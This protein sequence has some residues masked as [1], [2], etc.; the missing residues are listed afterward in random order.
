[1]QEAIHTLTQW[2]SANPGWVTGTVFL[3]ALV[4]SLAVAGLVVPG[5]AILFAVAVL[6]G[7]AGI[8][9]MELLAWGAAGA[10]IGD[11]ISF[12][13][14][15]RLRGRLHQVWPFSRYPQMI[16]RAER[17]FVRHG[18]KSVVIGRFVGPV[19]PVIPMVAGAFNMS[20][21]R[22]SLVNFAS[23]LAW[24]PCYL[25][26]GYSVGMALT[27]PEPVPP[28]LYALAAGAV[29]VLLAAYLLFFRIQ[30][31]L[32]S[33]SR[34]YQWLERKMF[35]YT[36]TH[37]VWRQLSSERP[38][39]REEFPL[40]SIS[41][42]LGAIGSFVLWALLSQATPVLMPLDEFFIRLTDT[43]R[44]PLT[45]P[46]VIALTLT[47]DPPVLIA[48]TL[49]LTT[50]LG[51]RGYYS[52]AVHVL[53]ALLITVA[54]VILLK[55]GLSV[56]RPS[57][58]H[59]PPSGFAFPSGHATG[60]TVFLGLA[61][62]FV[63]REWRPSRRWRVYLIFSVPM[64]LVAF[65]RVILGVHWFSDMVG[66]ILLG[67]AICG[68]VRASFSRHDHSP[69]TLDIATVGAISLW[70]VFLFG[71]LWWQWPQAV[72]AYAPAL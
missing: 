62:A 69:L 72:Q 22:F 7:K 67:L 36:A 18:G 35:E 43:F 60:I 50:A 28:A 9:V 41:L 47:G 33:R 29:V 51:F 38:S 56:E 55:N 1:M 30:L 63:A 31:G 42:A 6:A 12:W 34:L 66:G 25:L 48:G 46:L 27:G 57:L 59:Q 26:P 45:D 52:A 71:Y 39:G 3:T 20:A 61:S 15:R 10:I 4:E 14:G 13:L 23:A 16:R 5:V 40:A 11:G 17:L 44:N 21:R 54:S 65:S 32:R 58:V 64:L 37:R 19:R 49:L 2:L 24:S 53:G 8:P 68:L 70:V